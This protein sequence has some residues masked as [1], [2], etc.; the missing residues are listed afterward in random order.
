LELTRK[1]DAATDA[2]YKQLG[3]Q[4]PPAR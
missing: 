3:L 4:T 1:L 2:A